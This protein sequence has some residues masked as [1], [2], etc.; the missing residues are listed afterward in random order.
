MR[1]ADTSLGGDVVDA[2]SIAGDSAD[3]ETFII[4]LVPVAL[5]A[6]S[7]DWV[8]S[9]DAAA[10]SIG[11]NLIDAASDDA[12]STLVAVS[13]GTDALGCLNIIGGVSGTLGAFSID[14][15]EGGKAGAGVVGLV[16]GLV[17]EAGDP[18]DLEGDIEER[19]DG[20]GLADA[21]YQVVSLDADALLV[22]VVLVRA[23]LALRGGEGTGEDGCAGG[24]DAVAVVEDVSLD[25]VA[26]L[27]V[28]VVDGVGGAGGALSC[29]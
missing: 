26:G 11:K 17:G 12:E 6:D 8:I 3:T 25:A 15:E 24:D 16:V 7:V 23:A 28:G 22:D 21:A 19:V 4:D 27:G 1:K 18:A 5:T 29:N 20:A 10:L 13:L 9:S 2:L 14:E